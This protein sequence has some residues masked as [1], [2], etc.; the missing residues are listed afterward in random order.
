MQDSIGT[1]GG[2]TYG[3]DFGDFDN[4]GDLDLWEPNLAHPRT[5]PYSDPSRFMVNQGPPEF[6]FVNKA[7][8]MGFIY[9]EGDVNAAFADYDNDMDLDV[10]VCALYTGHYSKFY[11]ND[12][13][14]GFTDITYETGT[15]CHD[16]V[17]A[18][19][20]DVDHD[21]DLDLFIADRE[22]TK[23]TQLFM[24]RVGQDNHWL[25][26]SLQGVTANRDA[27]GA[28]V[29]LTAAGITQMREIK[30]GGGHWNAQS[31][32]VVHFG[33]GASTAVDK[34]TVRW[35]GGATEEFKGASADGRLL[36]VEGS[37]SAVEIE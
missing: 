19:W 7:A 32:R 1:W 34:L 28:R 37:G 14:A 16:S 6:F 36:V 21:G 13:A 20:S 12:G 25:A 11:R 33:L 15:A 18:S 17:S 2:H 10:V 27:V 35:P 30:G 4:D 3:G 23:R 29:T 8:E 5:M 26:L 31:T 24:N 9:D 22:G